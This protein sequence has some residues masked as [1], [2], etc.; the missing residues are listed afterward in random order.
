MKILVLI[1]LFSGLSANMFDEMSDIFVEQIEE[2][3]DT[4]KLSITEERDYLLKERGQRDKKHVQQK[5]KNIQDLEVAADKMHERIATRER[6]K[7][8]VRR[9]GN[10]YLDI[11]MNQRTNLAKETKYLG[12]DRKWTRRTN[13]NGVGVI[14]LSGI[15]SEENIL[16]YHKFI[17]SQYTFVNKKTYKKQALNRATTQSIYSNQ[18]DRII[19]N[20]HTTKY[21]NPTLYKMEIEYIS[22]E[23]LFSRN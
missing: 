19:F 6:L 21:K 9:G 12:L 2:M 16:K 11:T 8:E 20:V 13:T 7:E 5:E 4:S 23:E 15:L 14:S 18:G 17:Q 10:T 1:M 22:K 3:T